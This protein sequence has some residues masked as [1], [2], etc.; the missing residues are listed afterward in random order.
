MAGF[1]RV[2]AGLFSLLF[3]VCCFGCQKVPEIAIIE[4]T[5]EL[6]TVNNCVINPLTGE[7]TMDEAAVGKRPMAVVV[8]NSESARP[9]WGMCSPDIIIEGIAEAGITR[10]LWLYSDVNKIPKVGSIRSARMDFLEMAEGFDAIFVHC[11]QSETAEAAIHSRRID[12]INGSR[13]LGTY[14]KRDPERLKKVSSEHTV[15]TTGKMLKDCMSAENYRTELKEGYSNLLKFNPEG[16]P[17]TFSDGLCTSLRISYS[18]S[19][20]YT[21]KYNENDKTYYS[22]IGLSKLV[23][24]VEDSGKQV[25]FENLIILYLPSYQIINEKGTYD[26]DLSG[27]D[28][29]IV[30]NG[31]YEEIEW[32][33]SNTPSEPL[34]L[35]SKNGDPLVLNSGKSY[36]GLVPKQKAR[37][38]LIEGNN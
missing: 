21:F 2:V 22:Y 16:Q 27:G 14:L 36:I 25:H 35:Y 8:Q 9:Q 15:Y 26:M 34:K 32:E 37:M 28:G 10:M 3:V 13:W 31:S 1:R 11:G 24:F 33:K 29:L 38:T 19:Y 5:T 18:N 4:E 17:S 6:T 20:T 12:T 7:K 23:P 30:S